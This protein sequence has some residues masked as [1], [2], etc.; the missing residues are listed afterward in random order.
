MKKSV[1]KLIVALV[2]VF[3]AVKLCSDNFGSVIALPGGSETGN[4]EE[5]G[6]WFSPKKSSNESVSDD[7]ILK[8]VKDQDDRLQYGHQYPFLHPV[9]FYSAFL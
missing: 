8:D 6:G 2:V 3:L 1:V 5:S 4:T 9:R 7:D